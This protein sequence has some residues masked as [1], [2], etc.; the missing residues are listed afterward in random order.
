MLTAIIVAGGSSRR[1]GFDKI[2]A[3]LGD[4]PVVAHAIARFRSDGVCR[5]NHSRWPPG[6]NRRIGGIA[7]AAGL[8]KDSVRGR[9]RRA[10][11][12]FGQR[13]LDRAQRECRYVAVHDAARPLVMPVQIERVFAAAGNTGRRA[14]GTDDRHVE[15]SD[16]GASC[17]RLHRSRRSL[18]DANAANFFPRSARRRRLLCVA[19][20]ETFHHGRSFGGS[21]ISGVRWFSCRTTSSISRSRSRA[22]LLLAEFVLVADARG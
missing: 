12:G 4:K 5:R 1:M 21:N 18:R 6:A 22:I 14:R 20:A 19:A 13:R 3:L 15:A 2:F 9:R 17:L 7:S 16:G 11:A 10:P 8:P